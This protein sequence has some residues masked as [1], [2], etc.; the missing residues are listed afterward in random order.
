MAHSTLRFYIFLKPKRKTAQKCEQPC[1]RV[2]LFLL[3]LGTFRKRAG[4]TANRSNLIKS[5]LLYH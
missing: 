1:N 3:C 2:W 5:L 4:I